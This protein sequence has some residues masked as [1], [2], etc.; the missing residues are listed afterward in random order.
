MP[1]AL[2]KLI[3]GSLAVLVV[4]AL[5]TAIGFAMAIYKDWVRRTRGPKEAE[6]SLIGDA[7]SSCVLSKNECGTCPTGVVKPDGR[8]ERKDPGSGP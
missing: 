1:P 2:T 7:C 3:V 8:Q 4:V 5:F 6:A